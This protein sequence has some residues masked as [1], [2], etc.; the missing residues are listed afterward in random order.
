[1]WLVPRFST[2][3]NYTGRLTPAHTYE[4]QVNGTSSGKASIQQDCPAGLASVKHTK[5]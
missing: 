4:S 2:C 5:I 3:G 1:M